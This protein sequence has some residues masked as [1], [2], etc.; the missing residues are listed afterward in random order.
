MLTAIFIACITTYV[1]LLVVAMAGWNR[2]KTFEPDLLQPSINLSVIIAFRNESE[3]IS[4]LIES[5]IHQNY[6]RELFEVI[7]VD[8]HSTDSSFQL[9][10]TVLK[11]SG[12]KYSLLCMQEG[13]EGKKAAQQMAIEHAK[14]DLLVFT[15]ADCKLQENWLLTH[16]LFYLQYKPKLTIGMVDYRPIRNIMDMAERLDFLSLIN[17][18]AGLCSQGYP[19]LCN[20]AN[21]AVQREIFSNNPNLKPALA[22]GDDVFLLHYVKQNYPGQVQ[23]LKSAQNIVYTKPAG[24]LRKF[25]IQRIRWGS[26]SKNYTDFD[27]IL[28]ASIVFVTS[29]A[30]CA[31]LVNG[32]IYSNYFYA[33]LIL[34][35]SGADIFFFAHFNQF[36]NYKKTLWLI[37]V[38]N[39]VYPIYIVA[40][41]IIANLLPFKWKDR[42]LH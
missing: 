15:D 28:V 24:S 9:A 16:A 18:S 20:G 14:G 7:L 33:Y 19:I 21:L 25:L 8:D 35:K 12:I 30:I 27:T 34:A 36:W 38:I 1:G 40:I 13:C 17:I 22:S 32:F 23:V 26:K 41:G 11:L 31:A 10:Q 37:P 2:N 6:P 39:M 3:N 4:A 5:L 42:R 29:L